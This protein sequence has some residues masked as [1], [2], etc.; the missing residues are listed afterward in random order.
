MNRLL[1]CASSEAILQKITTLFS[2][3]T[4]DVFTERSGEKA[5]NRL[6]ADEFELVIVH[7][8]L[9]DE[10]GIELC[11]NLS[12]NSPS[13]IMLMCKAEYSDMI[14]L[15]TNGFGIFVLP[16]PVNKSLFD[17]AVKLL[18]S[19]NERLKV[20]NKT[21]LK[22]QSKLEELKLLDRAKCALIQYLNMTEKDA[23]RFIEKQ[24]MDRRVEKREIIENILKT[25]EM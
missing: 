22:L 6:M 16:L 25:Y 4:F 24:A 11:K 20:F 15:K 1:I 10:D 13:G 21:N 23:H 8:P 19:T 3:S 7:A 12:E 18:I 17:Q 9:C 2:G 5:R 14:E